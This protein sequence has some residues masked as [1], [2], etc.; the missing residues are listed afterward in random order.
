MNG[1]TLSTF[2]SAVVIFIIVGFGEK[3]LAQ[4]VRSMKAVRTVSAPTIDGFLE[5]DIWNQSKPSSGFIQL[6]PHMWEKS[7]EKTEVMVLYDDE[8]IYIGFKCYTKS[9]SDIVATITRRDR[10]SKND[11]HASIILDTFYDLRSGYYFCV[12]PLSTQ[13][14]SK[15]ANDGRRTD[16]N[17]DSGWKAKGVAQDWGWSAEFAIPLKILR[18]NISEN[19]TWG[20]NFGRFIAK[21]LEMDY[22]SGRMEEDFRVSQGGILTGIN[23][24]QI[25]KDLHIIPYNTSRHEK[26]T[27]KGIEGKWNEEFGL[28]IEYNPYP[29]LTS[30]LTFNPDFASVEGD[31]EQ[32]N[33]TRFELSFPE[34]RRFFIE[35]SELFRTRISVFYPRRIGDIKFGSKVIGKKDKYNFAVGNFQAEKVEEAPIAF[36]S[37]E[38]NITV[39]RLQRDIL[40]SSTIGLIGVNKNWSGGY[41]RVLSFD[42]TLNLPH[43]L[44]GTAQFVGSWPGSFIKG[45]GFFVRLEKRTNIYNYHL[46][47]TNLGREFR[48]RVNPVGFIRDDNR[49]EFD[50]A[51]R[52]KFWVKKRGLEFIYWR[53]NYNIYWDHDKVFKSADIWETLQFYFSNKLS[54]QGYYQ[55]E[56][57]LYEKGFYN[58]KKTLTIGYNTEEWASKKFEYSWGRNYYDDFK[59]YSVSANFKPNKNF[60]L[61]YS[62]KRLKFYPDVEKRTTFINILILNY[63][64]T[65]DLF[66]RIF[67]QNNTVN[68][69]YYIYSIFGYRFRPP[70]SAFYIVFTNDEFESK[71]P[72]ISRIETNRILFLKFSH[73]LDF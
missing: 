27:S 34:K 16:S 47:Y 71:T 40:K 61:E 69:R 56:Y 19:M 73:S 28:D 29:N 57:K 50:S 70:F 30:N 38:S 54:L 20:I 66:I 15:I 8:C 53:S 48:K 12:N 35:G 21:N 9:K 6:E 3:I 64:F 25:K 42:A 58:N 32:I 1:K 44:Y 65:P 10:V 46:R 62:L 26:I 55:Y 67:T 18:F 39:T 63:Q 5:S 37:P 43:N 14:D 24:K 51:G 7:T 13:V 4:S 11:D 23:I 49:H 41:N 45:L 59:L 17:W 22:W 2:L 72:E 33:L 31:R 36:K 60:S 52:Y 68:D